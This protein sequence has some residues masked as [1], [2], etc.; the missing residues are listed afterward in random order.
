VPTIKV[1]QAVVDHTCFLISQKLLEAGDTSLTAVH[2]ARTLI[3][4]ST[5]NGYC[6]KMLLPALVEYIAKMAPKVKDGSI[7]ESHATAIGEIWKAFGVFFGGLQ[8]PE[9][10]LT[11]IH[12]RLPILTSFQ[13]RDYLECCYPPSVCYSHPP[14]RK[15]RTKTQW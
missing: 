7:T 8:D 4:A 1:S 2:C 15:A 13:V 12:H 14:T 3:A 6:T 5:L 9:R 11:L 10:Q